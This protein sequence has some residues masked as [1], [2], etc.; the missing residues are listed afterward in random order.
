M[1]ALNLTCTKGGHLGDICHMLATLHTQYTVLEIFRM[2]NKAVFDVNKH[3]NF[4]VIMAPR[5]SPDSP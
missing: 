2:Q 3:V 1:H 5:K 4:S